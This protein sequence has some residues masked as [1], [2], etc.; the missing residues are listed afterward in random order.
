MS[1]ADAVCL[2]FT[3]LIFVILKAKL[4]CSPVVQ[5]TFANVEN[6]NMV[7]KIT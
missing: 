4:F 6:S 3:Y 2:H 7:R 5:L 1:N